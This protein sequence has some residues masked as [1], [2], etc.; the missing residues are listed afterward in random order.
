MEIEN[1][2]V[3]IYADENF[4]YKFAMILLKEFVEEGLLTQEEYEASDREL[5]KLYNIKKETPHY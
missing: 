2:I 1:K 4:R 5:R 3:D